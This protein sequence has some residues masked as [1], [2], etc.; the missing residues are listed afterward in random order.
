MG[1]MSSRACVLALLGCLSG[2]SLACNKSEPK[3]PVVA[4][5]APAAVPA[6]QPVDAATVPGAP[7]AVDVVEEPES[8]L[9]ACQRACSATGNRL[10]M[11]G[12]VKCEGE[13]D[14]GSSKDGA[15]KL[16]A[17]KAKV[18]VATDKSR[19]ACRRA[20]AGKPGAGP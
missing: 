7:P 12:F 20:C 14:E 10:Q 13:G 15:K 5:P 17:C 2:L 18:L 3:A 6:P 11:E 9:T 19:A 1:L 16:A 8:P 4:P